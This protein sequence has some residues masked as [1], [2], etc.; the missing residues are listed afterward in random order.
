MD[1]IG[2]IGYQYLHGNCSI[3]AIY[4]LWGWINDGCK[5]LATPPIERQSLSLPLNLGSPCHLL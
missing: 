4:S 2:Y 3:N 5:F 1:E